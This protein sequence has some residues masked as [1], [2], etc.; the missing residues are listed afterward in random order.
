[1]ARW[2]KK[3]SKRQIAYAEYLKTEHWLQLRDRALERDGRKCVRCEMEMS[4]QVHHKVYRGRFEDS[5]LED[6]ETLCRKCHREEHGFGTPEIQK[7]YREMET[8]MNTE[9]LVTKSDWK[10]FTDEMVPRAAFDL[11]SMGG[12]DYQNEMFAALMFRYVQF[13]LPMRK[14]GRVS[15]WMD[16]R[17][18]YWRDRAMAVKGSILGRSPTYEHLGVLY[19]KERQKRVR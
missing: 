1:M 15:W 14:Y 9:N 12:F 19:E 7:F 2:K 13:V 11:E 17:G 18:D 3:R 16:E 5:L 8:A 10:R 6:L 4:L